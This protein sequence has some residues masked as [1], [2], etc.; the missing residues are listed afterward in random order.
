MVGRSRRT[1]IRMSAHGDAL[2]M[3]RSHSPEV[4]AVC[5]TDHVALLTAFGSVL[6]PGATVLFEVRKSVHASASIAAM[7]QRMDSA[8]L[9]DLARERMAGD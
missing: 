7:E 1:A 6:N 9:R 8:W 3:L 2:T 4:A 5:A